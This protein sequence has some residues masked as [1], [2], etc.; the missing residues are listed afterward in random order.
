MEPPYMS[1]FVYNMKHGFCA[2]SANN[3]SKIPSV[4]MALSIYCVGNLPKLIAKG[5]LSIQVLHQI[6][7]LDFHLYTFIYLQ[8]RYILL[9]TFESNIYFYILFVKQI[10]M[11]KRI[12]YVVI[13][14]WLKRFGTICR[15]LNI[16]F[17]LRV[18]YKNMKAQNNDR[19]N[20]TETKIMY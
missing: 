18:F 17:Y 8:S 11:G 12:S 15:A 19:K 2:S 20:I 5:F 3:S 9:Y 16:V 7:I 14:R 4:R 13:A 1:L 10:L 6:Y